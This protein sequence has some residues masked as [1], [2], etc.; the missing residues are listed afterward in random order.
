MGYNNLLN[1][2]SVLFS[3]A[4]WIFHLWMPSATKHFQQCDSM[5]LVQP[6]SLWDH[7]ASTSSSRPAEHSQWNV[8]WKNSPASTVYSRWH[9]FTRHGCSLQPSLLHAQQAA[10]WFAHW[11]CQE[12]RYTIQAQ[13]VRRLEDVSTNNVTI[14]FRSFLI[15]FFFIHNFMKSLHLR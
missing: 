2:Y 11:A 1:S 10:V 5:F 13:Q 6:Q 8:T 14:I 7:S 3:L 9:L 4:Y 15:R 12:A